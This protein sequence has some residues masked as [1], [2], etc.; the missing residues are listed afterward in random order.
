MSDWGRKKRENPKEGLE[1]R[2]PDVNTI[3]TAKEGDF[4]ALKRRAATGRSGCP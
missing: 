4:A 1:M 2:L 3:V